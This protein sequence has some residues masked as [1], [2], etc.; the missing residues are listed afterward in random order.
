MSLVNR[1]NFCLPAMVFRQASIPAASKV[2]VTSGQ[3]RSHF[4]RHS[5]NV[6]GPGE[7]RLDSTT[8]C[9]LKGQ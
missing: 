6:G 2:E 5:K 1:E 7:E 9:K 3:M 8:Q 4:C